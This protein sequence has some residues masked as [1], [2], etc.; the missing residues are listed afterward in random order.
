MSRL[1]VGNLYNENE[2]GAPVV[3]GISTFSSPNYFVPP[4]GTTAQ[5]PQ[6]P[7]E[8]MIRFNTDSGHLEYYSGE[9]WVDVIVNNNDLGGGL[10]G[11]GTTASTQGTGTR[12]L[13]IGGQQSAGN[14]LAR[15][16]Y[17]TISTLGD[18][19]TFGDT[20][21]TRGQGASCASKTRGYL[22]GGLIS[23]NTY[24]NVID[25]HEFSSTGDFI[26]YGDLTVNRRLNAGLSNSTRG[27]SLGGQGGSPVA[28]QDVI[29]YFALQTTGTA[30]D[31]GNLRG[32]TD[33]FG[34]ALASPIRGI[35]SDGSANNKTLDF[36]TISTTGDSQSFGDLSTNR[37]TYVNTAANSTR[38]IF[39]GGATNPGTPANTNTIDFITI[40]TTGNASDFGDL[41]RTT[42]E[43]NGGTA[44][45]TRAIFAGGGPSASDTID[46]IEILST[47]NAVDF[48]NLQTASSH[49]SACSN[50]HGGL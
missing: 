40:A 27:I 29:D 18:A 49:N 35:Y 9:L 46:C 26:D 21:V 10:N 17:I 16:E 43:C 7:G 48:G 30:Q 32:G 12:A 20:S 24:S 23:P 50:G 45:P 14:D 11:I 5:R 3:S 38:G 8:G 6:N 2:D 42:A 4:S 15:I 22:M 25:S 28:V 33:T 19:Q 36:I 44:S 13:I 37:G 41:T 1:N 39:A 31:F 47:G 34:S